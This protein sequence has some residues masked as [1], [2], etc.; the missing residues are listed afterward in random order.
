MNTVKSTLKSMQKS[1][2]LSATLA[3]SIRP[4]SENDFDGI[5]DLYM[6][7]SVNPYMAYDPMGKAAFRS[8]FEEFKKRDYSWLIGNANEIYAMCFAIKGP[9]RCSHV[10]SLLSLA[11]K[12]DRQGQGLGKQ[13]VKEALRTLKHDGFKRIDLMAESDN[14]KAIAFYKSLG[15]QID[16]RLPLY[17]RR[18]GSSSYVDELIM[19]LIYEGI[20]SP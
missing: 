14:D 19:S 9:G 6:D 10:A 16:G 18:A 20:E 12:K 8:L 1:T 15:F 4:M 5:Y 13:I 17:L 7:E 3:L 11:V 2:G